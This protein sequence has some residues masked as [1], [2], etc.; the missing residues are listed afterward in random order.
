MR[1]RPWNIVMTSVME[2]WDDMGIHHYD[3][4]TSGAL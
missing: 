4:K 2:L 1:T 3:D